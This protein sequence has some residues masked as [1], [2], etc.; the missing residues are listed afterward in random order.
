MDVEYYTP[1]EI[2]DLV[3]KAGHA[4]STFYRHVNAGKIGTLEPPDEE[5]ERVYKKEDVD[6]FL[7]RKPRKKRGGTSLRPIIWN[8]S[9]LR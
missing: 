8:Q 5:A 1:A 3:K 9:C 6:A 7:R 2:P 4:L